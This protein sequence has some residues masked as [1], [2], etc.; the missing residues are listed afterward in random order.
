[1]DFRDRVFLAVAEHLSFSKAG[2]AL[3]ISQPAV[4]CHIRELA[5]PLE[6]NLFERKGP[7]IKLTTAGE[8]VYSHVKS[9]RAVYWELL[10]DLEHAK[11]DYMRSLRVVA[12][13]T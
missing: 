5:A 4:T 10:F 9:I 12:G 1:M 8:L 6:V 7:R 13:A 11:G 2:T 3:R